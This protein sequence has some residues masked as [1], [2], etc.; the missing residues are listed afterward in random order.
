[1]IRDLVMICEFNQAFS[2]LV[3]AAHFDDRIWNRTMHCP[4][5]DM[6]LVYEATLDQ[7]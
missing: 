3:Q 5:E 7:P 2:S 4:L 6:E 1:M